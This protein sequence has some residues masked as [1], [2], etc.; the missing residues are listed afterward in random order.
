M[1]NLSDKVCLVTGASRGV[2]RGTALQLASYGATCYITGR[3]LATLEDV[4]REAEERGYEGTVIPIECDHQTWENTWRAFEQI[5][6]ERK[7]QLDLLVNDAHAAVE[8]AIENYS[9]DFWNQF[10]P[11]WELGNGVGPRN[12]YNS[13]FAARLMAPNRSG[14]IVDISSDGGKMYFNIPAYGIGKAAVDRIARNR[15]VDLKNF[16]VA[17]VSLWPGMVRT[18]DMTGFVGEDDQ[19]SPNEIRA[20][21]RRLMGCSESI[22]FPGMCIA[23]MLADENI[24][25]KT[26]QILLTT[27]LADEYKFKDIDGQSP[28][29]GRSFKMLAEIRGWNRLASFLPSWLKLSKFL[30]MMLMTSV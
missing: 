11:D 4:Q 2:G 10:M 27:D 24:M 6:A 22:E 5:S 29:S 9:T 7:G 14:L 25:K 8:Y 13:V 1:P 12:H 28:L 15:S 19:L 17:F 16:N 30:Y 23:H 3:E 18:E 20:I 21:C 26:G